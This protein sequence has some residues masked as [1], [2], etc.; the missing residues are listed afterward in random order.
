MGSRDISS[1]PLFQFVRKIFRF[2]NVN[3]M[4]RALVSRGNFINQFPFHISL[5]VTLILSL[6][7]FLISL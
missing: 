1:P 6:S 5:F 3:T 7:Q 4:K 2:H